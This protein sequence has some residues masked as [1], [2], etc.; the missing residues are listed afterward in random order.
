[1][2]GLTCPV[3]W[4]R[5][6]KGVPAICVALAL[7]A[8][9]TATADTVLGVEGGTSYVQDTLGVT[10]PDDALVDVVCPA[11]TKATGGG[12]NSSAPA[13]LSASAMW[14]FPVSTGWR[15]YQYLPTGGMHT[16]YGY[17]M[18]KDANLRFPERD[19]RVK[20]G[21]AGTLSVS[22]GAGRHVAGGGA[23][24]EVAPGEARLNSSYPFD[25]GDAGKAPDDGWK[26]RALNEDDGAN[27]LTV[28]AVCQKREPRY[29]D[30]S[31]NLIPGG[32][33]AAIPFCRTAEHVIGIGAKLA[34]SAKSSTLHIIAP[35]DDDD[36]IGTLPDDGTHANAGNDAGADSNKRLTGYAI[37]EE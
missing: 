24:I 21:K 11:G 14:S 19:V 25:S 17:L 28:V 2:A 5:T 9:A 7:L 6:A 29:V 37:C 16:A 36:D 32:T 10:G 18:C 3:R 15:A 20:G 31:N 30:V 4:A 12:F 13:H 35:L 1:M 33:G 26:A 34:G 27:F 23:L 22:C 8:P